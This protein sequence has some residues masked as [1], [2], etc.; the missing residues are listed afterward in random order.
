M[1]VRDEI[2]RRQGRQ[3][4]ASVA[5][6]ILETR[7]PTP[8]HP[9]TIVPP[10]SHRLTPAHTSSQRLAVILLSQSTVHGRVDHVFIRSDEYQLGQTWIRYPGGDGLT[11]SRLCSAESD[12]AWPSSGLM[13]RYEWAH[14]D[15]SGRDHA[16]GRSHLPSPKLGQARA[17][18]HYELQGFNVEPFTPSFLIFVFPIFPR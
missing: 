13:R 18:Q 2:A 1:P 16:R 11:C 17:Y 9:C 15:S 4:M 5:T 14:E 10:S 3:A 8:P 12:Q 6:W 7:C